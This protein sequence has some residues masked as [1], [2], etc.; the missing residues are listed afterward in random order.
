MAPRRDIYV[1]E[2]DVALWDEAEKL[3]GDEG[4]A[5]FLAEAL[6]SY[7]QEHGEVATPPGV[8]EPNVFPDKLD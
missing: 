3:A 6:R 7:I 8:A 1:G 4:L 2:D 5:G